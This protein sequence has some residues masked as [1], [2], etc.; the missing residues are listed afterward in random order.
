MTER[1]PTQ[2][3][4]VTKIAYD[5]RADRPVTL[6][7]RELEALL[8][9]ARRLRDVDAGLW[10]TI[11]LL[12]LDPGSLVLVQEQS[13]KHELLVRRF[14]DRAAAEAFIEARLATYERMW[15]GCGCRVD[16]YR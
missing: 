1:T 11:R 13:D 8:G 12:E 15:D 3:R 6:D 10:G 4:T 5:A 7:E 9:H 16:Y 14:A 2:P